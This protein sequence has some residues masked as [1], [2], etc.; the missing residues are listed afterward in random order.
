MSSNNPQLPTGPPAWFSFDGASLIY[1]AG[2][3]RVWKIRDEYILKRTPTTSH[4]TNSEAVT[5]RFVSAQTSVPVPFVYGEWRS[6]NGRWHYLLEGR[7]AG[8]TLADCWPRLTIDDK[9]DLAEQVVE[10]MAELRRFTAS[11]M[12]SVSGH[13]LPNNLFVP[14]PFPQGARG[15]LSGTW[16]T[17][18]DIFAREFLPALQHARVAPDVI[19]LL[20]RTMPPCAGQLQFTHCDLYVGNVMVDF[21]RGGGRRRAVVSAIIDW[22]SAGYWPAWFQHARITHGCSKIDGDWKYFLSRLQRDTIPYADHGRVWWDTVH[23]LLDRPASLKAR[24]WLRLLVGYVR[25]E[26]DVSELQRY[27]EMD[28]QEEEEEVVVE[29]F[30]GTLLPRGRGRGADGYY[31]TAI[32]GFRRR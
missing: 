30:R 9:L 23:T 2:E 27:Q 15:F 31:S 7:I 17:D 1:Q 20:R 28:V 13:R 4:G 18:D 5:H 10:Y 22:E 29:A 8:Q 21:L 16:R 6:E 26:R 11:H 32:G 14:R 24:A 12:R 19:R 25:G 3:R